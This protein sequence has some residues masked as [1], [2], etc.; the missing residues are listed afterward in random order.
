MVFVIDKNKKP[1]APCHEARARKLLSNKKATVYRRFP[2]TIIL[3][4]VVEGDVE[5]CTLKIDPGSR[6]TGISI[7]C[8]NR[9]LFLIQ[10]DHKTTIKDA[11]IKRAGYRRRRRNK[12]LRYRKCR[13]DN[14]TRPKGWLPPSVKS[15]LQNTISIAKRLIKVCPIGS[16]EYELVKFDI[17]KLVNPDISGKEYQEGPL[18]RSDMRTFLCKTYENTCQYCGGVSHDKKMEWEH[19][20]PK[21]RGG[22][23]SVANATWAC[24]SCNDDKDNFTPDEWA[25][26]INAKKKL[27]KLDQARLD[28]IKKVKKQNY[29]LALAGA[30]KVNSIRKALKDMLEKET[31]LPISVSAACVTK[32]NRIRLGLAKDHCI[33]AACVGNSVPD[34]LHFRTDRCFIIAAMGRGK[35]CRTNVD[36]SGFKCGAYLP[37]EKQF[38]GFQTGYMVTA[39][40]PIS[41]KKAGKYTGRVSCRSTGS[42]DIKV[43]KTRIQGISYKYMKAIH[44]ND[45]YNY[46]TKNVILYENKAL[47]PPHA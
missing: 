26:K 5:P 17:Q 32:A 29:G 41:S 24:R 21:S 7:I 8:R 23:N 2:F 46:S 45:G 28:G 44:R 42:F 36:K 3:K 20:L 43:G 19:I 1:L 13:F 10:I 37:R 39:N 16:I 18:F 11:L 22:S 4:R 30:A 35:H 40:V 9:V 31:H 27:S 34:D 15:S 47:L 14:R 12:N 6:H 25:A 33:D 38:F